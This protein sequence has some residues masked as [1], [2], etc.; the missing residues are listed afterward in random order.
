MTRHPSLLL[1]AAGTLWM[2]DPAPG[3]TANS[4]GSISGEIKVVKDGKAVADHS[5]V[6]VYVEGVKATATKRKHTIRQSGLQF[7]PQLSVVVKGTSVA[8]PNDDKVFHNVFSTSRATR[9][10]L[11][12]YRSGTAKSVDFNRAGVVDVFCNIH[13]QMVSRVLVVPT[14]HFALT[15]AKGKFRVDGIPAGSYPV[16]VWHPN[17]AQVKQTLEIKAGQATTLSMEITEGERVTDHR[18]KDGSQYGRYE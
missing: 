17:G 3:Q 14:P 12:L 4:D 11:G 18:R 1:L 6:V 5:R 7:A 9:F 13:P 10:D 2:V 16:V 15:D 8:F